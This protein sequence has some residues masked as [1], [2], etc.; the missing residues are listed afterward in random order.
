METTL[1]QLLVSTHANA[2]LSCGKCTAVCPLSVQGSS[3]SPRRLVESVVQGDG[4]STLGSDWVWE[5]LGCLACTQVCPA[6]VRFTAFVRD[7][8]L[9]AHSAAGANARCTHSGI[10]HGWMHLMASDGT[11]LNRLDW[12]DGLRISDDGDTVYFVGCLPFYD[13]L[14]KDI[15]A[16]GTDIARAVVRILNAIGVE[17]QVLA[18]EVC[19]GH[20]LLWSGDEE[21]FRKLAGRN[22]ELLRSS[23]AKRVVTACPE[24]A[25]ALKVE[26]PAYVGDT[27]LEVLHI[28][29]LIADAIESGA[30]SLKSDDGGTVTFHDSCWLGRY[31]GLYEPPRKALSGAGYKLVE[32]ADHH[33]E[34]LCC[35]T[36]SWIECGAVNKRIQVERLQQAVA[37]GADVL[38]TACPKCQIHFRCAQDDQ[39]VRDRLSM[40]IRDLTTLLAEKLASDGAEH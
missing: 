40:E 13:P 39:G 21:G 33:G 20:D 6:N 11:T 31:Q 34:A 24:C 36:G 10:I 8:R 25:Y 38:V 17:P 22:I 19:C 29:Q 37:T 30:L 1:E 9:E 4:A 2:C 5:C 16:E 14:F 18:D 7:L 12:T 23:G 3:F 26:Y 28:S 27:N 32:M 35:G 15:G